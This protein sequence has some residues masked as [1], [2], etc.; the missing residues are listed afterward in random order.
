MQVGVLG[1][2]SGQGAC[3]LD[4]PFHKHSLAVANLRFLI[5]WRGYG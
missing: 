3:S 4:G 2:C 1:G 5:F